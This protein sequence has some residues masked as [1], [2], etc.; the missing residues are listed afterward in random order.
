MRIIPFAFGLDG[1]HE[2]V[3]DIVRPRDLE[4]VRGSVPFRDVLVVVNWEVGHASWRLQRKD[5]MEKMCFGAR[6][7]RRPPWVHHPNYVSDCI[8]ELDIG[9]RGDATT[10]YPG[11]IRT[12]RIRIV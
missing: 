10:R 5:A 3:E 1:R 9:R 4:V 2:L 12:S 11:T 6:P 7:C 8:Q